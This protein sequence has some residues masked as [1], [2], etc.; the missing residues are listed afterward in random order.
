MIKC[1]DTMNGEFTMTLKMWMRS[2]PLVYLMSLLAFVCDRA[3]VRGSCRS[4]VIMIIH[5]HTQTS[6]LPAGREKT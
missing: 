5:T 2:V 1:R 6:V 4:Q 3:C